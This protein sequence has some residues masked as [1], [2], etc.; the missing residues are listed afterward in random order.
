MA[1]Y[2]TFICGDYSFLDCPH[3]PDPRLGYLEWHEDARRRG[4]RGERQ[5]RCPVCER[6]VWSYLWPEPPVLEPGKSAL[7]LYSELLDIPWQ[8]PYGPRHDLHLAD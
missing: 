6:Y 2:R 8:D 3:N 4:A 7:D 1:R 5:F